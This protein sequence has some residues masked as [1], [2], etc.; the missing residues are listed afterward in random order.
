MQGEIGLVGRSNGSAV[1]RALR[2]PAETGVLV[3]DLDPDGP[4]HH[5]G[6]RPGDLLDRLDG[7]PLLGL[8]ELSLALYRAGPGSILRLGLLRE[9]ERRELEVKVRERRAAGTQ[10]ASAVTGRTLVPQLGVFV[11]AMDEA[12]A[13]EVGQERGKGGVLVAAALEQ[14]PS[15]GE[16]LQ[17]DDI[18]Y[19]LNQH[20]IGS[21]ARLRELLAEVHPGE[22]IA[23]QVERQGQ[24]HYVVLELPPP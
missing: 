6:L 7:A 18:V 11:V 15:I 16:A 17:V 24:L 2:L 21:T 3:E 14:A 5:A 4:A 22:P 13:A 20:R 9:G 12:L 1:A 23:L 8:P 10:V 19:R